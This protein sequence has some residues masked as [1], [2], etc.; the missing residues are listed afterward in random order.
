MYVCMYVC[1][2]MCGMYVCEAFISH[3]RSDSDG[4]E[5]LDVTSVTKEKSALYFRTIIFPYIKNVF[6]IV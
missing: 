4:G 1:M 5:H 6:R 3:C 2:C